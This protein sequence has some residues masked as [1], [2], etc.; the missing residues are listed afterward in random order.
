[1]LKI[2]I[3]SI[4]VFLVFNIE[5]KTQ[6]L[7]DLVISEI[8]A[9]P[10]PSNG[11]PEFEYLEIYNRSSN[12]IRLKNWKLVIGT[13]YSTL[14]DSVILPNT[15]LILCAKANISHFTPFGQVGALSSLILPNEGASVSIL[16]SQ[17]KLIY[18]FE[19]KATFWPS[20]KRNGG[21]ALEMIDFKNPCGDKRNWSV[22]LDKSGGTPGSKNSVE[23][24]NPDFQP[25]SVINL[26]MVSNASIIIQFDEKIDSISAVNL[27]NVNIAGRKVTKV[28]LLVPEL[29]KLFLQLDLDLI[30]NETY[31]L[32]FT[33]I[34]D[35]QSNLKRNIQMD[36]GLPV[37]ADSGSV[38]L[39]EILFNP[40]EGGVDFI[41]LFNRS[42]HYLSLSNWSIGNLKNGGYSNLKMVTHSNVILNPNSYI[43]LS[44][45]GY[46]VQNQYPSDKS[47]FFVDIPAMPSFPNEEGSVVILNKEGHLLD[48]LQYSEKMHHPFIHDVKGVS[49]ERRS[50]EMV[51]DAPQNWQSG[52]GISGYASPGL[53]NSQSTNIDNE[54]T[55]SLEVT[56]ISPNG[57]GID[58]VLNIY[59]SFSKAGNTADMDVYAINGRHIKSLSK[60][61]VIGTS[62]NLKWDGTD[63]K[64]EIV[65]NGYY[66]IVSKIWNADGYLEIFKNKV[67]VA[68]H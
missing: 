9:D 15:Y 37:Q 68:H 52:S 61:L 35:C 59:L 63:S 28:S 29:T 2:S 34:S 40:K 3:V 46:I 18:H 14:P 65:T 62:D 47:R 27:A 11:L 49:L 39:N 22:S 1:M 19:Y 12:S 41:E 58:D 43:F 21:F 5:G 8:M 42:N 51:T 64:G 6:G 55:I 4:I 31:A 53:K 13:R 30:P 20:S 57:D 25:P 38:V 17:N 54:D 33:S 10:T 24:S 44:T 66:L 50:A 16:S 48:Q 7:N 26:E 60:N 36:F 67:V 45:D 32:R 56:G 23:G